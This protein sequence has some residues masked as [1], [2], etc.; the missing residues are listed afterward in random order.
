MNELT[1]SFWSNQFERDY[2]TIKERLEI[3]R[4]IVSGEIEPESLDFSEEL[5][6]TELFGNGLVVG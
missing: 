2:E 6:P 5:N 1:L 3:E 4:K